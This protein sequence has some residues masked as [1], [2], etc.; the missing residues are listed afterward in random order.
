V[1][2]RRVVF[3]GEIPRADDIL[4]LQRNELYGLSRMVGNVLRGHLNPASATYPTLIAGFIPSYPGGFNLTL[5]AGE[6]YSLAQIDPTAFGTLSADTRQTMQEGLYPGGTLAF[7]APPGTVGESRIDLVQVK[8]T[9]VDDGSVVLLYYNSANPAMPLSG[10]GGGGGSQ[11]IDRRLSVTI[12]VKAG[13]ASVTPVA[14]TPDAGFVAAYYVTLTNG[15]TAITSGDVSIPA[16]APWIGGLTS[17]HHTGTPGSAPKIDLATETQGLLP[18]ARLGFGWHNIMAAPY[19]AVGDGVTDDS[20][21]VQAA[22]DAVQAAG[23]GVVFAP[24]GKSFFMG[25]TQIGSLNTTDYINNCTLIAYG[26]TFTWSY[27][28]A[29]ASG[30]TALAIHGNDILVMGGTYQNST[31]LDP[32]I[33]DAAGV[34][35]ACMLRLGGG[36]TSGAIRSRLRVRD[37]R[38]FNAHGLGIVPYWCRDFTVTGCSLENVMNAAIFIADCEEDGVVAFNEINNTGDDPIFADNGSFS[39]GTKRLIIT[40]NNVENSRTKGMGAASCW[41]VIIAWNNIRNT[42]APAIQI[43]A[44]G[45]YA[46][47]DTHRCKIFGN[48]IYQAGRYRGAGVFASVGAIPHGIYLSNGADAFDQ[49]EVSHNTIRDTDPTGAALLTGPVRGLKVVENDIDGVAIGIS[50]GTIGGPNLVTDF[51]VRGNRIKNTTATALIMYYA[52]YGVVECNTIRNYGTAGGAVDRAIHMNNSNHFV[53]SGNKIWNGNTAEG[54]ILFTSCGSD[55]HIGADNRY[56]GADYS[57]PPDAAVSFYGNTIGGIRIAS[58]SP[59]ASGQGVVGDFALN[60]VPTYGDPMVH[61]CVSAGTPGTWRTL[62]GTEA[63]AA[64]PTASAAFR[65]GILTLQGG[66]GVADEAYVCLKKADG[67]YHWKQFA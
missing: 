28:L 6:V 27:T 13:T 11:A 60:A 20:V 64:L 32:S 57:T 38:V 39:V 44:N 46:T 26:A 63:V 45:T 4:Q 56:F 10:P 33:T 50:I 41:D 19:N 48:N 30:S 54:S 29:S 35:D 17:Q 58:D 31:T 5:G 40:N 37:V 59:P 22:F 55:S 8:L 65:S 7:A 21:A 12:N 16:T 14:P 53:V 9:Q 67:S 1:F 34:V 66:T 62:F 24:S 3:A 61:Q 18:T 2:D 36:G 23:G 25:T 42:Y 52:E 47:Q 15:D 49:I 43:E 51:E